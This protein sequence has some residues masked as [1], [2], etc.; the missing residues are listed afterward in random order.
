[1]LSILSIKIAVLTIDVASIFCWTRNV[2]LLLQIFNHSVHKDY[3]SGGGGVGKGDE[4]V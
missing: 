2:K 1:V 4:C 3:Y